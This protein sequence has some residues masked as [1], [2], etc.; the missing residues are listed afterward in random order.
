MF[1]KGWPTGDTLNFINYVLHPAKGQ[2]LVG[3][4]GFVPLY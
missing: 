2:R 1:T 3:E 4:I